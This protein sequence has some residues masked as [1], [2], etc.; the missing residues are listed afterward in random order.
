MQTPA[1]FPA[2]L[3][4][5]AMIQFRNSSQELPSQGF[6]SFSRGQKTPV[7]SKSRIRSSRFRLSLHQSRSLFNPYFP[8]LRGVAEKLNLPDLSG[9]RTHHPTATFASVPG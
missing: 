2:I 6:G 3:Q 9:C 1:N 4:R 7:K 5:D 8:H